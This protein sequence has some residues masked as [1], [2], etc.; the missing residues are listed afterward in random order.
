MA[1]LDSS[2][3]AI[4]A[5]GG[6][7]RDRAMIA[8]DVRC[9]LHGVTGGV[10]ILEQ[11]RLDPGLR[12]QIERVA[13]ASRTLA[14]VLGQLL[15]EAAPDAGDAPVDLDAFLRHLAR[16]WTGE[17]REHDVEF[18]A[19]AAPDAPAALDVDPVAL[20]R[21]FGNVICNA[22]RHS[23][24]GRVRI[25]VLRGDDGGCVLR[26]RDDGPGLPRATLDRVMG[27]R[28]GLTEI[29]GEG[30]GLGLHIAR[31]LCAE[32]GGLLTLGDAGPG[33]GL[34]ARL[35]FPPRLC[36]QPDEPADAASA[37]PARRDVL[38]GLRVLLAEDNPTNQMVATQ[39]LAAL[40]A[41]VE[42]SADGVEAL[43][44]FEAGEFD[45]VIADIEMPRMSGLDVIR[46]IRG[47]GDRRAR[48]PIVA[49]TAYAMREHRERIAAAG[50]NGLI[51]K[52][53]AS[54]EAFGAA[55]REH[56]AA[57]PA[58]AA[59]GAA[60]P[61]DADGA[62]VA[63][64]AIFDALCASIGMNMM[65]ELLDK[66]VADLLQA[67]EDLAAAIEALDRKAIRSA[68]HILI[69]VAGAIGATRLQAC[70]RTLNG[71]AHG[72][73]GPGL[74]ALVRRCMDEIEAAVAF[75]RSRRPA[76]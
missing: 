3:H 53:I 65:A 63:D 11:A 9:A 38:H 40:G 36:V 8:H 28:G 59:G 18:V 27:E 41:E 74:S 66:V 50:A 37:P 20:E 39:M 72:D 61:E 24:P 70:A 33:G 29:R 12:E 57:G 31:R 15:D 19:R 1:T 47:R 71:A 32:M 10:A 69:S 60:G 67:R 13:A 64:L 34:E 4:A 21:A 62:P 76:G 46:A 52:P 54:I 58:A 30:R 17:A 35:A 51:S 6:S 14:S 7:A 43:Q 56:I 23:G 73:E 5:A 2:M 44:R 45:L 25:D 42:V 22:V 26:V 49:L 48:V 75:A 68:S 55:L 16:R